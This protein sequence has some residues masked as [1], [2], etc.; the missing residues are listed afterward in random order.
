[1]AST[2][3][4]THAEVVT[5]ETFVNPFEEFG[6]VI[7]RASDTAF[8]ELISMANR[9]GSL[10]EEIIGNT[11][12]NH[13]L[14]ALENATVTG[15]GTSAR[16]KELASI[17]YSNIRGESA[18]LT[19]FQKTMMDR[20]DQI[21]DDGANLEYVTARMLALELEIARET[22]SAEEAE[23]LFL[24]SV[25]NRY[26]LKYVTENET[27]FSLLMLSTYQFSCG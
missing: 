25:L 5:G 17:V 26:F 19:S 14:T 3:T 11:L 2:A 23:L 13:V 9:T 15:R 6:P 20:Q 21:M 1:M 18:D 24:A 22:P 12:E 16:I 8:D 4:V 27:K 7:E 10:S